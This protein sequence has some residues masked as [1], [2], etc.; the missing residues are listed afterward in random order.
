MIKKL[1]LLWYL[2]TVFSITLQVGKHFWPSFSYI[3][4]IR[5]DY[6]SPTVYFSDICV[7]VL[8]I[9][10]IIDYL[11]TKKKLPKPTV[12]IVLFGFLLCISTLF[13][14]NISAAFL[15]VMKLLEMIFFGYMTAILI[16]PRVL[17][18]VTAVFFI[19][20]LFASSLAIA[21][22]W[23]QHSIGG[24]F[25]LFGERTFSSATGDIAKIYDGTRFVV[26][27]YATFPHPN[28]LALYLFTGISLV[29][30]Q[31]SYRKNSMTQTVLF[32]IGTMIASLTLLITFSRII[33]LCWIG[34]LIFIAGISFRKLEYRRGIMILAV[35]GCSVLIIVLRFSN[36][37]QVLQDLGY[38]FELILMYAE[39]I[40][41]HGLIG[42]G[43]LNTLY[44]QEQYQLLYTPIFLQ[45][46]HNIYI[47]TLAQLGGVGLFFVMIF[48]LRSVQNVYVQYTKSKKTSERG[49]YTL[50][51][52]MLI[53]CLIAGI[54]DHYLITLQQGQLLF[55]FILGL[56]WSRY[57]AVTA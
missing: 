48:L 39:I 29:F 20:I 32:S 40:R 50:V 37:Q 13:A 7:G 57:K 22:F 41:N 9:L 24:I 25:Y 36:V 52:V 3:S 6:L 10:F 47:L 30:Y 53:T 31:L 14:F 5:I 19:G 38:R 4:G 55:A 1:L 18:Y 56:C 23:Q 34:A 11:Q 42:A 35:L 12:L 44:A 43:L 2:L 26:R 28:V 16:T 54:F 46:V 21:Q 33:V 45:P 27:P 8:F 51:S 49:F 17:S 15:G